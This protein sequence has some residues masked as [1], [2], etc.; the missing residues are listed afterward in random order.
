MGSGFNRQHNKDCSKIISRKQQNRWGNIHYLFAVP[1][2]FCPIMENQRHSLPRAD[3]TRKDWSLQYTYIARGWKIKKKRKKRKGG[4]GCIEP[5]SPKRPHSPHYGL[6]L[7]FFLFPKIASDLFWKLPT[8]Q[9]QFVWK[10]KSLGH[11][12]LCSSSFVLSHKIL[13]CSFCCCWKLLTSKS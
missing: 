4:W 5:I 11:F 2:G 13:N 7:S 8:K 3:L 12:G 6:R 1:S 10:K 9:E